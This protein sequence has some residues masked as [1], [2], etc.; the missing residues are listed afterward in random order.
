[1][2]QELD[3]FPRSAQFQQLQTVYHEVKYEMQEYTLEEEIEN[4]LT[5]GK[6]GQE[7]R[8]EG[9]IHLRS[10]LSTKK[11]EL[12]RLY[13]G[14]NL[15]RGFSEDC[16]QS[17]L[18]N[19]IC[20]LIRLASKGT[21]EAVKC[22]GELGPCNLTTLVLKPEQTFEANEP[23][24]AMYKKKIQLLTDYL[25]DQNNTVAI[26]A[27]T[28]L[29]Y[30]LQTKEG[31]T[32]LQ[33]VDGKDYLVP[34]ISAKGKIKSCIPTIKETE[35]VK[36][37]ED[38]EIWCPS[39]PCDYKKWLSTLVCTIL[40]T[41]SYGNEYLNP[42]TELC[43]FKD[44]F[45]AELLPCLVYLVL[46]SKNT[47][48]VELISNKIDFFFAKHFELRVNTQS[49][50]DSARNLVI[51]MN[52]KSVH[53]MLNVVQFV[54]TQ[55]HG[56]KLKQK[57]LSDL[58]YLH[59]AHAALFCS[60]Y[61]SSI[62]YSELWGMDRKSALVRRKLAGSIDEL[63]DDS[64]DGKALHEILLQSYKNIGDPDAVYG[65]G[66]SRLLDLQSR[67]WYFEH[68]DKWNRVMLMQ[69]MGV[70]AAPYGMALALQQSG[71]HQLLHSYL[72]VQQQSEEVKAMQYDCCWRLNQWDLPMSTTSDSIQQLGSVAAYEVHHYTA[73]KALTAEN[74]VRIQNDLLHAR[75]HVMQLLAN[76]RLESSKNV[77]DSLSKLQSLQELE[78]FSGIMQ[79][80][81]FTNEVLNKWKLQDAIPYGEFQYIEPILNQRACLIGIGLKIEE[82]PSSKLIH[83]FN[84]YYSQ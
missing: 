68:C 51:S 18:H 81:R 38:D 39:V 3:P 26:A 48:C 70:G 40:E 66:M 25:V 8:T 10:L 17:C 35:F 46:S 30:L 37:L 14:L 82:N 36:K 54:R 58:N 52:K 22:L 47:K 24:K 73:L 71:L 45:A 76:T 31:L 7:D 11:L 50:Q 72:G 65:C 69:D 33:T 6:C 29:Y 34:F 20:E 27:A 4:F 84:C 57:L 62:F 43:K 60:S 63:C 61:F 28:A 12:K 5:A 75:K 2:I 42:L 59:V 15:L 23:L 19:L 53:C 32:V 21:E 16:S 74:Y 41:V 78:D 80:G 13:D 77:Y 83:Q 1:V 64:E 56:M 9:L 55:E 67:V 49:S 44:E 79:E